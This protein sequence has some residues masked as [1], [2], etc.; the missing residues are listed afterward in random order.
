MLAMASEISV[1]SPVAVDVAA[2]VAAEAPPAPV[3]EAGPP[4]RV[5][6][7][8]DEAFAKREAELKEKDAACVPAAALR[9][10]C[11]AAPHALRTRARRLPAAGAVLSCVPVCLFVD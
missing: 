10:S 11:R 9:V 1:E 7:P 8:D 2:P 4:P 5:P 3:V 6:R